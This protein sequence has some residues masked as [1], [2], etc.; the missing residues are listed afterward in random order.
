MSSRS[1]Y[2]VIE[3][4]EDGNFDVSDK[5]HKPIAVSKPTEIAP[6]DY[7]NFDWS[8][9]IRDDNAELLESL[10]PGEFAIYKSS[11]GKTWVIAQLATEPSKGNELQIYRKGNNL[12]L[13]NGDTKF[14]ISLPE[15]VV[16]D[17][18]SITAKVWKSYATILVN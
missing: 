12:Q 1:D 2:E 15:E 4:G 13:Q 7:S 5:G 3:V 14:T 9:S 16:L 8:A 10:K 18:K 6:L 11:E 17:N